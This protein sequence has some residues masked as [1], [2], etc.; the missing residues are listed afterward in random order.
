MIPYKSEFNL[1]S[2]G[3]RTTMKNHRTPSLVFIATSEG[4]KKDIV[5]LEKQFHLTLDFIQIW[6]LE[7]ISE[8]SI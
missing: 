8:D 3:L 1:Q 4:E 6:I 2:Q 7:P 5:R